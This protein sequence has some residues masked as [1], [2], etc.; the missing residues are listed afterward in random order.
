M[1]TPLRVVELRTL[2]ELEALR[3][4]WQALAEA[5][6]HDTPYVLPAF[7]LPWIRRLQA[8][9]G[10]RTECRFLAAWDGDSLVGLAPVVQREVRR[11]GL[12]LLRL[13]G[14][15]EAAPTPPCDLLVRG[16]AEGVIEAF[17]AHWLGQHDWDVLD[18]PTVPT[19]STAVARL[20]GLAQAAGLRAG[21]TPVLETY[22]VPVQGSWDDFHASRSKKTRQ[23][24]RRG[25]RYFEQLGATRFAAYPG[26]MDR[27]QALAHVAQVV[28]R[29]WKDH[30]QGAAGWNAFLRD[31]MAEFDQTGQLRLHFLLLDGQAVA[32]L[33]DVP[34]KNA[35]YAIHNAYD[36]RYPLGNAGQ[37][38]LA[39]AIALAHHSGARRYDFTGNKDYLQR[40]TQTTRN[41]E[42][43][44]IDRGNHLTRLKLSL[45]DRLHARRAE[46]VAAATDSDKNARKAASR[47]ASADDTES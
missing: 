45:Y 6:Q 41:F 5:A 3:G 27:D 25:L 47:A 34:F 15:P 2:A 1:A 28:A 21:R 17:L 29:S 10:G 36:L 33:M 42:Q 43:V 16:G 37:L 12:V 8:D 9:A 26:E 35:W 14:F 40:W 23:N 19:E 11:A 39:H 24:L 46:A 18:L 22:A 31:V 4:P 30:E 7:L 20:I 44:R 38:M 32:Y 13:R